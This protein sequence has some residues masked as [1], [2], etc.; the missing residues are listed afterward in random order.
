MVDRQC[1]EF[2]GHFGAAEIGELF[3]MQFDRQAEA[4]GLFEDPPDLRRRKGDA[5]AKSVNRV[6]QTFA[7]G[8]LKCGNAHIINIGVR[9]V[10]IVCRNGVCAEKTGANAN[11]ALF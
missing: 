10:R 9:P 3:G 8:D 2:S 5:L 1:A 7:K 4:A 11:I 6:D